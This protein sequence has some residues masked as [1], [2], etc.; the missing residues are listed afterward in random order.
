MTWRSCA[1]CGAPFVPRSPTRIYCSKRCRQKAYNRKNRHKRV[2]EARHYYQKEKDSCW[3][4][5]STSDLENHHVRYVDDLS[6]VIVA[7]RG[8]HKKLH[9][10]INKRVRPAEDTEQERGRPI[11]LHSPA[12]AAQPQSSEGEAV[13]SR[14]P[15]S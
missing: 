14:A 2:L 15:I 13:G 6:E 3:F 7:C 5:G 11:S 9:T 1:V 4:C 8:C 12:Y 10:I